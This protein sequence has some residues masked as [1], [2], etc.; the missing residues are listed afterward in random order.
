MTHPNFSSALKIGL[1]L[2][3]SV[4]TKIRKRPWAT[5]GK[6]GGVALGGGGLE[7]DLDDRM[8]FNTCST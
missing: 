8:S 2:T 3:N 7:E 4:K 6:G 5:L 1:R